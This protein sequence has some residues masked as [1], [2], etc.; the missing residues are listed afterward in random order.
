MK[1]LKFSRLFAA[2][3]F[4]A[5]LG[6][7]GCK[8]EPEIKEKIVEKIYVARPLSTADKIIGT[9]VSDWGEKYVISE[10]DYDNYSRYDSN[11]E[12]HADQ[13]FLYYSTNDLYMRKIDDNSGYIY[14]KF[15][16]ADH[17]GYNAT[18]GQWYAIYYFD[19][20]AN[21]V[22]ISGAAGAKGGCDTLEE[23][24]TEFTVDNGYMSTASGKYSV[25]TKE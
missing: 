10:T 19:L 1:N 16:D 15:D 13:W 12:Y 20:T 5:V 9:W 11:F 22:K 2:L 17:V 24:I 7:T 21:S 3:M 8:P 23:A 18:A 6:L 25:C 14:G 4:V